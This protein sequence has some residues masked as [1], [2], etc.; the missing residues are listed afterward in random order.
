MV[1]LLLYCHIIIFRK[2][3]SFFFYLGFLSRTFTNLRTAEEGGISL[4]PHYHFHPLRRHLDFS[5]AITAESSLLRVV[6]AGPEPDTFG[7][8]AQV[9]NH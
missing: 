6:A 7:F 4:T 1:N 5:R 3:V 2:K 8:G 9:A